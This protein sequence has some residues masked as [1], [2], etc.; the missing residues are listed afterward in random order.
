MAERYVV[1]I[2]GGTE[3]LRAAVFDLQ[4]RPRAF[5]AAPYPTNFPQPSWAEQIPKTGGARSA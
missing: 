3:S 2:D 4:G 1:G 5:A